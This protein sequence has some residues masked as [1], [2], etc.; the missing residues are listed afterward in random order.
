MLG[1]DAL[2]LSQTTGHRVDFG[3]IIHGDEQTSLRIKTSIVSERAR[4]TT[5]KINKIL[6]MGSPPD[7]VLN[8]HCPEC[9][10]Q[11]R[12]RQK[13]IEVDELSL[14]SGMSPEERD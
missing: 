5:E 11:S 10:F 7:L 6:Q 14:F 8:R 2:V 13:A 12:C 1:F 4:E 9:E 3:R